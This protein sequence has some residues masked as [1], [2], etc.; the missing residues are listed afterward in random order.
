[1]LEF[2]QTSGMSRRQLGF[3]T[4][5]PCD[6]V[7]MNQS[8]TME[9]ITNAAGSVAAT[10]PLGGWAWDRRLDLESE[11]TERHRALAFSI[12]TV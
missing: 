8:Q 3:L 4:C 1:M 11:T 6:L 12:V 2:W 10:P 7:H 9:G 5:H